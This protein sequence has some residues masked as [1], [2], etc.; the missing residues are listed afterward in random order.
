[1]PKQIFQRPVPVRH[2]HWTKKPKSGPPVPRSGNLTPKP[3]VPPVE[4]PDI[5][6]GSAVKLP[7]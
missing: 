6:P 2:D 3:P 7:K 5:L 1:M 4:R